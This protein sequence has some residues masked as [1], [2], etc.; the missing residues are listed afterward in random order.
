M[1]EDRVSRR[2]R[3][4]SVTSRSPGATAGSAAQTEPAPEAPDTSP[5]GSVGRKRS[6]LGIAAVTAAVSGW[7]RS[8]AR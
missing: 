7:M 5:L 8:D 1:L 3:R 4:Q 6:R 2:K